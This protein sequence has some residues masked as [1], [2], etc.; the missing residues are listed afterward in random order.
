MIT[1]KQTKKP[2]PIVKTLVM[3]TKQVAIRS[4]STIGTEVTPRQ[5]IACQ[6]D[7]D[8]LEPVRWGK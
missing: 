4:P 2:L 6:G 1:Y 7:L 8:K 5:Q 3:I